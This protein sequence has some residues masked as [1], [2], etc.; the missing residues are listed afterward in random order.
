[1]GL[2]PADM[3]RIE[4]LRSMPYL[5]YLITPE[6]R[7]RRNAKI[8]LASGRCQVCYTNGRPLEVH[9]R[10]YD[11]RGRERLEDLTVLCDECHGLFHHKL[12]Q[13]AG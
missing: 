2:I 8:E 3:K 6:W 9:H 10:T 1:M 11:R 13:E 4:R 5:E 12:P 7:E